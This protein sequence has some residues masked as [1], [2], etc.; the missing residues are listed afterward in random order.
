MPQQE[1]SDCYF[2]HSGG[3]VQRLRRHFAKCALVFLTT[4]VLQSTYARHSALPS[5][6]EAN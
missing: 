3:F 6:K 5:F 2:D 4:Y 1:L